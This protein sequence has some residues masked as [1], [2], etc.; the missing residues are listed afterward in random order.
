MQMNVT[1]C[2]IS[3]RSHLVKVVLLNEYA[4]VQ[5]RQNAL[6]EKAN[7]A[8]V[9]VDG[10]SDAR[11]RSIYGSNIMV[12]P[13]RSVYLLDLQEVS[14]ESHTAVYLSGLFASIIDKAG[15]DRVAALVT[16][17]AASCKLARKLL[18]AKPE[19]SH[20]IPFR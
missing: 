7:N 12:P 8:T 4:A 20:I 14:L 11:K 10:W 19:F 5:Q 13:E 3:G 1:R 15:R 18:V 17:N 9:A 16:D 6:L 2:N